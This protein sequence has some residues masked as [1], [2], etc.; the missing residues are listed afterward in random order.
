M[1]WL[2][3]ITDLMD[4]SLSKPW[5]LVMDREA[6]H[7]AVHGVAESDTTE[8]LNWTE[9]ISL[10]TGTSDSLCALRPRV[11]LSEFLG[12]SPSLSPPGLLNLTY[13]FPSSPSFKHLKLTLRAAI[14]LRHT[15]MDRQLTASKTAHPTVEPQFACVFYSLVFWF[16]LYWVFA[17]AQGCSLWSMRLRSC[18][19]WAWL[20]LSMWDLSFST[21]DWTSILYI[22]RRIPNH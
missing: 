1:R 22:G 8:R 18:Y 10:G 11:L 15:D 6:W 3:G 20:L 5:E 17:A 13:I 9:L 7:A 2:D 12:A 4:M 21:R 19:L 14:N 16:W